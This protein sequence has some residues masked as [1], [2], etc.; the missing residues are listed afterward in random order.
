M[1]LRSQKIQ[2]FSFGGIALERLIDIPHSCFGAHFFFHDDHILSPVQAQGLGQQFGHITVQPIEIPHPAHIARREASHIRV[3]LTQVTCCRHCRTLF[4]AG[5]DSFANLTVHLHLGQILGNR[6]I[7]C[8]VHSTIVDFF[9]NVHGFSFPVRGTLFPFKAEKNTAV[10]YAFLC[11]ESY[12]IWTICSHR[13][14]NRS[15][16]IL[17]S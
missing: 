12:M 8:S 4:R 15:S 13:R 7:Q 1:S 5:A 3:P 14:T 17:L 10:C 11:F 2:Q 6:K 16:M 9:S